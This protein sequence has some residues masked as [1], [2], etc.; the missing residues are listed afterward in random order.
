MRR[1]IALAALA[2]V[3]ALG[4]PIAGASAEPSTDSHGCQVVAHKFLTEGSPGHEGV[5]NAGSRAG[6]EGPCGFG[7]PPPGDEG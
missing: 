6:G 3:A 4:A 2:S 7:T 5:Q 1:L